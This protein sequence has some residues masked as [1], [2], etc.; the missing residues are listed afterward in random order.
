MFY[1]FFVSGYRFKV[2]FN[3]LFVEGKYSNELRP[4]CAVSLSLSQIEE[5][6][7]L[8]EHQGRDATRHNREPSLLLLHLHILKARQVYIV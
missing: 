8:I 2:V 5:V 6:Y 3:S 1:L 7:L 4:I